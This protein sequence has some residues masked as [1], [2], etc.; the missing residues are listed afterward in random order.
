VFLSVAHS[1]SVI[2]NSRLNA[3]GRACI[4]IEER[5]GIAFNVTVFSTLPMSDLVLPQRFISH[6]QRLS[7]KPSV[8]EY[9]TLSQRTDFEKSQLCLLF[10]TRLVPEC[11]YATKPTINFH[12]SLL[13]EH[14]GLSGYMSAIRAKQ[15]AIT[16]HIVDSTIDEGR[17]LRQMMIAPFPFYLSKDE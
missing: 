10:F 2:S 6:Y 9:C 8:K 4:L 13:P 14:P 1:I 3:L 12:P 17:I 5:L 7:E 11:I 16:A 15:L